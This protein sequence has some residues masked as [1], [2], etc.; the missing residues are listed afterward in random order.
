MIVLLNGSFGVGKSTI[1]KLLRRSLPKSAVYNPEWAGSVMMRL[2]KW[3]LKGSGTDDFQDINLWRRSA[4]DGVKLFTRLTPG[5][6]IVPMTFS[7]RSYFDEFTNGIRQHDPV[8][9]VFCLKASL[10]ALSER[11]SNRAVAAKEKAWVTRRNIECAQAHLDLHFGEPIET[12][13]RSPIEVTEYI[14]ARLQGTNRTY[15]D[16]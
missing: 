5:P 3:A 12:E 1:A 6:I 8:L 14:I 13:G 10:Q 16:Q 4:I 9:N 7:N 11:L 15:K 2:P